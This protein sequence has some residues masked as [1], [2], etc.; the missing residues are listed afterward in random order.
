MAFYTALDENELL[1]LLKRYGIGQLSSCTGVSDGIE[2]STY[3]LDDGSSHWILTLFED[4][5]AAELPFLRA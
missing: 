3:I 2:N 1:A 4:L 5:S